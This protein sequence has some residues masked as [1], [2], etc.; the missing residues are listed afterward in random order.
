ML[1]LLVLRLLLLLV[2]HFP[3][4]KSFTLLP[5][6]INI[7]I[8]ILNADFFL[9]SNNKYKK[10]ENNKKKFFFLLFS[11]CGPTFCSSLAKEN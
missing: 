3:S 7:K 10:P 2:E 6:Q 9:F 11:L 5:P 4:S 8:S 1:L